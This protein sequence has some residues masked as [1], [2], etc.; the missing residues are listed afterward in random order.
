[1][2]KCVAC[3]RVPVLLGVLVLLTGAVT[4]ALAQFDASLRLAK[5]LYSA[6]NNRITYSYELTVNDATARVAQQTT[7]HMSGMGGVL[8]QGDA[9]YWRN[10]GFTEETA[11]WVFVEPNPFPLTRYFDII[12]DAGRTKTDLVDFDFD[13]DGDND[14]S[15]TVAGPVPLAP[16]TYQISGTT[17]VD[18]DGNGAYESSVDD[19]LDGVTVGLLDG[20]GNV[21]ATTI[22]NGALHD[23]DGH[24]I[25]NYRFTDV[26]AGDYT[27]EVPPSVT[28]AEGTLNASTPITQAVTVADAD[29]RGV[30][31]GYVPE[32]TYTVSGTVF[33]DMDSNGDWDSGAEPRLQDVM[34]ELL[35]AEG[36]VIATAVSSL[37]PIN[38]GGGEYL[39]AYLFEDVPAGSYTVRAPASAGDQDR[40]DTTTPTEVA[41]AVADTIVTE[42]DFGY[43]DTYVEP[44]EVEVRAWVFFDANR[45]G[46]FDDSEMG[47]DGIDVTLCREAGDLTQ[48]TDDDGFT[49]FGVQGLGDYCIEV[50][51][52][53][54]YGLLKYWTSTTG[55]SWEFTITEDT[56]SPLDF[57]FGFYPS[58]CNIERDLGTVITGCNHTI[59]FWKHNCLSAIWRKRCGVQVPSATLLGFL[60]AVEDL[61]PYDDPYDLGDCK[62]GRAYWYL[63]PRKSGN[64]PMDKLLRQLLAAELNWVSGFSSS[65]PGLEAAILWWGEWVANNDPSLAGRLADHIDRWNNL[66]NTSGCW[67]GDE[68]DDGCGCGGR[69]RGNHGGCGCGNHHGRKGDGGC[70]RGKGRGNHNRHGGCDRGKG[71]SHGGCDRGKGNSHGG[72]C[73]R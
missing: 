54:E 47:F 39:G 60:A 72:G 40:Y 64:E 15:G 7:L 41:V 16:P 13:G 53:G 4:P 67:D 38:G 32:P 11:D 57:Y 51:D 25:G 55:T 43:V 46:V 20:D 26:P 2:W 3:W 12:A 22:A 10:A 14:H 33:I 56:E 36:N 66:G 61:G 31:F 45:N 44:T 42:I 63:H 48:Q 23:G 34:V 73:C 8:A 59:G 62:L 69:D 29:V 65:M 19:L 49:D 50:T 30:D 6:S 5:T 17:F 28:T 18:S 52:G 58:M 1:M 21:V 9:L 24:Y 68:Y 37:T 70:D 35:D 27:V 71:N